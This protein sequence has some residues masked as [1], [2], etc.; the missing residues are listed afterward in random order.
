MNIATGSLM[1]LGFILL[2]V[3]AVSKLMGL[4]LLAPFIASY[5]GYFTVAN[6]CLLMALVI[7]KFQK[8]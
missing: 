8:G 3:G 4:S 5:M 6:T 1:F 7:D 2:V